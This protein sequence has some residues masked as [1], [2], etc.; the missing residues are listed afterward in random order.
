MVSS[1]RP[2]WAFFVIF[3]QFHRFART[4][5]QS[6]PVIPLYDGETRNELTYHLQNGWDAVIE[7]DVDGERAETTELEN[8]E[9]RFGSRR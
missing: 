9:P 4:F 2:A 1:P 5:F 8:K 6:V 7:G 3:F